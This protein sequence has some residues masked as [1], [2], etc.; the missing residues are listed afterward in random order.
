[1]HSYFLRKKSID[2]HDR[3]INSLSFQI[4]DERSQDGRVVLGSRTRHSSVKR[5]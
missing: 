1:M 3:E 2:F 5:S 4:K